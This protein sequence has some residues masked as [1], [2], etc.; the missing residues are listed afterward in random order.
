V[1][2]SCNYDTLALNELV[3]VYVCVCAR[4][5]CVCIYMRG[6]M[7][8]CMLHLQHVKGSSL[9]LYIFAFMKVESSSKV[10]FSYLDNN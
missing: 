4:A 7:C 3:C 2:A 6:W 5:A 1:C 10:L 8:V 9:D